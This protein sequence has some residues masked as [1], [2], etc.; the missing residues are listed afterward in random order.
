MKQG[1]LIIISGPSGVGKGTL[2]KKVMYDH[3]LDA[4]FSVS[5]TT[6]KK[7]PKEIQGREYHFISKY[8]FDENLRNNEY[9]EHTSYCGNDYGTPRKFIDDNLNA[10]KNVILEIEASGARQAIEQYH[11]MYT[12]S[13]LLIPP[14]LEE[15][16]RRIR[17]RH[18]ES[19]E[20]IQ[21]RIET[22]KQEIAGKDFYDVVLTNYTLNKTVK[23]FLSSIQNRINYINA[24]ENN[25][26][27]PEGYTI[28]HP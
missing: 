9:L 4:V 21:R 3:L 14:T 22:A 18:S 7:R 1:L 10:G 25:E 8:K 20:E 16:E 5:D 26:E 24:I 12:I 17:L 19:E 27:P 2:R 28:K 11:G 15:L 13:F 6:R 23:R